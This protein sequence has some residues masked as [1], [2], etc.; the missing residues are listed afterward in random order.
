MSIGEI[1]SVWKESENYLD[2]RLSLNAWM[3]CIYCSSSLLNLHI[4]QNYA[5][6]NTQNTYTD[7]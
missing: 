7:T 4:D 6:C 1:A 3:H 2:V 5:V